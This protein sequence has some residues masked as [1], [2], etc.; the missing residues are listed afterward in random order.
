MSHPDR[1]T[2]SSRLSDRPTGWGRALSLIVLVLL[3]AA[4]C[5]APVTTPGTSAPGPRLVLQGGG[6]PS[7]HPFFQGGTERTHRFLVASP[8][9]K[10]TG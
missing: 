3:A 1:R 6:H 9:G 2:S 7:F 10:T 4:G 8:A 5:D